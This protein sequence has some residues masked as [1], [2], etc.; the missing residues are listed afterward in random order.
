MSGPVRYHLGGF[1]PAA[2]DWARLV[3]LIGRANAALARYD[4]LVAAIPNASI[5]LSPLTTQEA[6]LSSKI[7]GTNVTMGEV[8][9]IE[10][11]ADAEVTQPK[12]DDAEEIR[13]YRTAL[14]FAAKAVTERPLTPHLLRE[15]HALLMDGVRGRNKDPGTFRNEQNWIGQAGCP[16]EQAAF[17]PIPQAQLHTGLDLWST[18]VASRDEPDPLVQLAVIHAEFEALHPF[19]DGNGRLGRMIVPLF[20]FERRILNGPNFYMSGYLETRREQYIEFMRAIS[21]DGAWTPWCAFF[22][23]G[24]I[25]QASEN[26]S[27]A[28]AI[29]ELHQQ[30]Q[31]RVAELTHSQYAGLAV[32][33]IFS[34]P[35][36]ASPHFVG[37]SRIP[38]QTALRFLAVLR[39]GGI[40]RTIREGA[41]RRAAILA[42]SD[43]LN[44]AEGRAVL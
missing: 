38:R 42:F 30:M 3:P 41:G 9:E 36:F 18:Y 33:F 35:V 34:R 37:G 29:L 2:I 43:L 39:D 13:N 1:P 40:L 26:Q 21:R 24:L 25:E 44:I 22:L 27:K 12:R 31:R 11:G 19:K 20:L 8:L 14:S 6:V 17:V 7:E 32:D 16:I 28:Q 15:V 5:L 23:E 4:G 10:A